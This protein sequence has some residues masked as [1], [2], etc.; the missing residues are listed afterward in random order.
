MIRNT[1]D[2]KGDNTQTSFYDTSGKL[3]CKKADPYAIHKS[4]YDNTGRVVR[5]TYYNEK[6]KLTSP[7]VW[8]PEGLC[9]YDQWGNMN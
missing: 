5:Q 6:G 7:A 1:Y 4:E 3:V 8:A 2:S 9:K